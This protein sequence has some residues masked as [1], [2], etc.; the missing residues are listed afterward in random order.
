MADLKIRVF[1]GGESDPKTTVTIP[2]GVLKIAS[3]LIPKKAVSA[4]QAKGIDIAEIV[5]LSEDP[6]ARGTL[7]RVEEHDEDETIEIALE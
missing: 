5:R 6:D 2:G 3:K 4:L 7:I 1:K